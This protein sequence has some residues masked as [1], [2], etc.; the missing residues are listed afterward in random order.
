[1]YQ[2]IPF[3]MRQ[4]QSHFEDQSFGFFSINSLNY[5]QNYS[6]KLTEI[7][8]FC[9]LALRSPAG[10]GTNM[11]IC[12]IKAILICALYNLKHSSIIIIYS[13]RAHRRNRAYMIDIDQVGRQK[14]RG[15]IIGIG[16]DTYGG[17]PAIVHPRQSGKLETWLFLN[18]KAS[19]CNLRNW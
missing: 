6:K 19:E 2:E 9:W 8:S 18:P 7:N 5:W 1:M 14:D 4:R 15:C 10:M 16:L 11:H 17:S 12:E 3:F 13:C